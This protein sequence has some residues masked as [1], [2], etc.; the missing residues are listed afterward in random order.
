MLRTILL[1]LLLVLIA[2]FPLISN[3]YNQNLSGSGSCSRADIDKAV[4]SYLEQHP[5]KIIE[6]VTKYQRKQIEEQQKTMMDNIK[7]DLKKNKDRLLDF[8]YP[9]I[10][11]DEKAVTVVEFFDVSCGYCKKVHA[12]LKAVMDSN[13]N[14]NYIFRNFPILGQSSMLA[15]QYETAVY[16]F[17]KDQGL[18]NPFETYLNFHEKVLAHKGKYEDEILLNFVGEVGIDKDKF[19]QFLVDN[20]AKIDQMLDETK[21]LGKDLHLGGTP[22]FVVGENLIPGAIDKE[23]IESAIKSQS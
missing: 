1:V 10:K 15:A 23:T 6:S 7:A 19:K 2:S 8:N 4:E 3:W 13:K 5:D 21:K 20:K 18:A 11:N 16:M 17:A 12:E 22:A 9:S 14:V